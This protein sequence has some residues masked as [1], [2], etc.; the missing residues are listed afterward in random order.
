METLKRV[1]QAQPFF[2]GFEEEWLNLVVGCARNQIIPE[3]QF[4]F[5]EGEAANQ[6]FLLREGQ[7]ALESHVP[8]REP[9]VIETLSKGE[10]LGWS[11]LLPPYRWHFDAY[12]R[13]KLHILTFDASCLR[14]K[15]EQNPAFGYELFKRFMPIAVQRL[16]ATRMRLMDF[17]A[18]PDSMGF[19]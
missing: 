9:L 4:L 2:S 6:F 14:Q 13:T 5:R 19:A 18:K 1:V 11:W 10:I 15:M 17:Y 3:G 7:V 16:Q 12:A 8:R